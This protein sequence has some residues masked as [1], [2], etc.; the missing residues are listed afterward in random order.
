MGRSKRTE[1]KAKN[2]M[3]ERKEKY[4]EKT[5]KKDVKKPKKKSL[6]ARFIGKVL[7]LIM[8]F[9]LLASVYIGYKTYENG[10][11]VVG[12]LCAI[13]GQSRSDLSNLGT[14]DVLILGV[15]KDIQADLTD[16]IMI[17][18]FNPQ[19]GKIALL[20]IPRDTFV[21]KNKET[22]K[23]SDKINSL[24]T[25]G[26]DKLKQEI[27]ELTSIEIEYYAVVSNDAVINIVDIIGGIWF[28]VPIDMNYDDPTQ[29]LHIH[30]EKGYQLINGEK[31]EQLLRFRHNNDGTSYPASYGDN[32]FGRMKTQR[33]FI[34]ETLK[35]LIDIKNVP[36]I[37]NIK[38]AIFSNIETNANEEELKQYIPLSPLIDVS[39][40]KSYQLPGQSERCN[41][42]WFFVHNQSKTNEIVKE[43]CNYVDGK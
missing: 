12:F 1:K 13:M 26:T 41:E 25:K 18:R 6:L 28:D 23:G 5:W 7:L 22:A 17:V 14:V 36:K 38:N 4:Q 32:D 9:I 29:D 34:E 40:I 3:A 43:M 35:Q 16:T 24:Y 42:L 10:G 20:S 39:N 31:A 2:K 21:G 33:S 27:E 30:I 8:V 15:S 11:G 37:M 19:T